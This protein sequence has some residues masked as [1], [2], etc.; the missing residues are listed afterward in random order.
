M[1]RGGRGGRGR[2]RGSVSVTHELLRDNME[3]LG[4]DAFEKRDYH[5]NPLTDYPDTG[6]E[7]PIPLAATSMDAIRIKKARELTHRMQQLPYY[8]SKC[9]TRADIERFSD[10]R[11]R[12]VSKEQPIKYIL[13]QLSAEEAV[14]YIPAELLSSAATSSRT[15]G[16]KRDASGRLLPSSTSDQL[17]PAATS[18]STSIY[19]SGDH[20][21]PRRQRANSIN[22]QSLE[23][24]EGTT[25]SAAGIGLPVSMT[26]VAEDDDDEDDAGAGA[27]KDE[28][29]DNLAGG[30]GGLDEEDADDYMVDHYAS[31]DDY[32]GDDD[33]DGEATF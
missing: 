19:I 26:A 6:F 30:I 8:M 25:G 21:K 22:L 28:D 9:E 13:G 20:S 33:G 15:I 32:G 24:A 29:E 1:S 4:A 3:D 11:M 23:Q 14:Q 10:I 27:G 12:P 2:G 31:G 16:T 18:T 5:E 7:L 17:N